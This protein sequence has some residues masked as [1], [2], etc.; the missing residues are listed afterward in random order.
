MTRDQEQRPEAREKTG[1]QWTKSRVTG[2]GGAGQR[3]L[4]TKDRKGEPGVLTHKRMCPPK[5]RREL[6][7]T[8]RFEMVE[9]RDKDRNTPEPRETV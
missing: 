3:A 8:V 7:G 5:S 9:E 4:S 6:E 2:Q 1:F